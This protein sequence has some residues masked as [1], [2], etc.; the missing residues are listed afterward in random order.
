MIDLSRCTLDTK[1]P[2]DRNDRLND[3][4]KAEEIF[5]YRVFYNVPAQE[6]KKSGYFTEAEMSGDDDSKMC[7]GQI[8]FS[9]DTAGDQFGETLL[10]ISFEETDG[11]TSNTDYVDFYEDI[12]MLV[13]D[14]RIKLAKLKPVENREYAN[15]K[16]HII[17]RVIP[18]KEAEDADLAYYKMEDLAIVFS[19]IV[20]KGE[21]A[22]QVMFTT[23]ELKQLGITLEQLYEDALN[24]SLR[25]EPAMIRSLDKVALKL[26]ASCCTPE[27][28]DAFAKQNH[29]PALV[30]S[31]LQSIY[32]AGV[33]FYPHFM[34]EAAKLC[35][36]SF[37]ILP[38]SRNETI[39]IPE[40]AGVDTTTLS[41]LVVTVNQT[42]R[43]VKKLV[44]SVYFYNAATKTFTKCA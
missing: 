32:G 18:V 11:S 27:E 15:I 40:W 22:T 4:L 36:G 39:L 24:S 34:E 35:N 21:I 26:V 33:I 25:L 19:F 2:V 14:F 17:I 43:P 37:Y 38:S 42:L 12:S 1:I 7:G 31:N 10:W 8:E 29:T 44:D 20:Q 28:V 5:G 30:A 6:I 16:D 41:D 13:E 3:F 23:P 9:V